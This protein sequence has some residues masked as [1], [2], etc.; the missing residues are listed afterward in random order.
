VTFTAVVTNTQTPPTP[1]GSVSFT[2]DSGT[3]VAATPA[4][5]PTSAPANSLCATYSTSSLIPGSHTV[6]ASYTNTDGNFSGSS[7]SVT[8]SVKFLVGTTCTNGLA[9][10]VILPPINADGSSVFKMGSTVPT[11]F[12]V[13]DV[14][15]NSV[16]PNAAFPNQSVVKSYFLVAATVGT[17]TS[18]DE[19]A[20]STTPDSAFRWHSTAQQWIFNQATGGSGS[21]LTTKNATYLFQIT[22]IDG[23]IIRQSAATFTGQPGYQYGLK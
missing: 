23:T 1:T 21:S 16:G 14:N 15:G 6:S 17:V 12:V 10:G 13:C 11:K 4:T 3:P 22:L 7:G 8:Q 9:S 2:T 20:Y 5:C 19:T 18:V